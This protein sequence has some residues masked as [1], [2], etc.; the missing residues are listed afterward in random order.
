MFGLLGSEVLCFGS[1]AFGPVWS[2][3]LYQGACM[4]QS[5][6]ARDRQE[7]KRAPRTTQ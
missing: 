7:A 3:T 1:V 6:S 2:R 4:E 5:S